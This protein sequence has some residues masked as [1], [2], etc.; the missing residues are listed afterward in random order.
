M[1]DRLHRLQRKAVEVKANGI[2]YR[3]ILAGVDEDYVYLK[4]E[5]CWI[6]LPMDAVIAIRKKGKSEADWTRKEIEGAPKRGREEREEKRT[7]S[8]SDLDK[9]HQGKELGEWP[10]DE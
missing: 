2:I 6:T 10:E 7:Y 3:G 1:K 4:G 8:P 9:I 5:T